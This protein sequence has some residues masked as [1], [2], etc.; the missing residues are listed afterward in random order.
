MYTKRPKLKLFEELL[1]TVQLTVIGIYN[2]VC[3]NKQRV[4][5]TVIRDLY[6][7]I[8]MSLL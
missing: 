1:L 6:T 8:Y 2:I 5:D 7:S 3:L 4:F